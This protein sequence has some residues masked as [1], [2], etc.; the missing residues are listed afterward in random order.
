MYFSDFSSPVDA[1][2]DLFR[3]HLHGL[4]TQ[5][6][7][8]LCFQ[9]LHQHSLQKRAAK[10]PANTSTLNQLWNDIDLWRSSTLFQRWQNNVETTAIA[11]R[12][13]NVDK[14]TSSQCL[15]L[16]ENESWA[17]VCLSTLFGRWQNNLETTLKELHRF[18]ANDL[19]LFQRWYLVENKSWVNVISS[20]LL[21]SWENSI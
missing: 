2:R 13:F 21:R 10:L 7:I 6:K 18:N 3:K 14:S 8:S 15:I 11:L 17:D 12:R 16:V 5:A 4:P 20:M 9:S 1:Y 19:M